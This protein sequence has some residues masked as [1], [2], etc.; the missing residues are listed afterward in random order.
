MATPTPRRLYLLKRRAALARGD[1]HLAGVWRAKQETLA[2]PD[3]PAGFPARAALVAAG[4]TTVR[5][6][7]GA[8][9]DELTDL[10]LTPAQAAAVRAAMESWTMIASTLLTYQRQ[11]GRF[12]AVYNAPLVPSASRAATF[13]SDT[14]EMGDMATLRL[15]LDVTVITGTLDC[16]VQ[17][18]PDGASNW[19]A[20]GTFAQKTAVSSERN[21]FPG[22]DRFVRVVCT[23]VTGPATFS[24]TG[25]AC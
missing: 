18:S 21:V 17:T 10:G 4:Y 16:V 14:Y 15:L 20:L 23:I 7:D 11:D 3:L 9:A 1:T 2:W 6:L 25:E 24:I 8:A 12:A 13:T 22:A 5:D 19:Q